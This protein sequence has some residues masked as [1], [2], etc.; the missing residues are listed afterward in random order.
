MHTGSKRPSR[1]WPAASFAQL[2]TTL[3]EDDNDLQVVLTGAGVD[4]ARLAREVIEQVPDDLNHRIRSAVGTGDL[5][6]LVGFLDDCRCLVCNDTGVMHVARARGVPLV[7][8]IGPENDRRWGPHPLGRAPALV[9][10]QVVPGT[11]HN[12]DQ[13]RWN[14]SMRSVEVARVAGHVNTILS[15]RSTGETLEIAGRRYFRVTRDVER[16]SFEEL[17]ERGVPIPRVAALVV[18]DPSCLGWP[19]EPGDPAD[20]LA[21]LRRQRYPDLDIL[22]E[23]G[24]GEA[25][26]DARWARLIAET[27]A[28]YFLTLRAQDRLPPDF[29]SRCL[30]VLLRGPAAEASDGTTTLDATAVLAHWH[31]TQ[32]ARPILLTRDAL[33]DLLRH[34]LPVIRPAHS[35]LAP[36]PVDPESTHHR[37]PGPSVAPVV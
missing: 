35:I 5:L 10:R 15:G 6:G 4:E 29:I 17:G 36:Q 3:L 33:I 34:P 30:D 16:L 20:L 8:I 21:D 22:H 13:C 27:K 24:R 28:D 18:D 19:G 12:R 37:T 31:A 23:R 32:G 14:L 1:R 2:A 9:A 11:P 26:P 25:S 7:A